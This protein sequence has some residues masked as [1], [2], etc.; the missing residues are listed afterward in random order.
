[1]NMG[2]ARPYRYVQGPTSFGNPLTLLSPDSSLLPIQS[3]KISTPSN[4]G[5]GGG[6]RDFTN[7]RNKYTPTK[8]AVI[9][10]VAVQFS[11]YPDVNSPQSE[12]GKYFQFVSDYMK[13]GS[14]VPITPVIKVPS[15][16]IQIGSPVSTYLLG[17][18]SDSGDMTKFMTDLNKAIGNQFDFS[19]VNQ[20]WIVG[21]PNVPAKLLS[22]QMNFGGD[23]QFG[24]FNKPG[25]SIYLEGSQ[26]F[27]S[28]RQPSNWTVDPWIT[29]HEIIGHQMGLDDHLGD[30]NPSAATT[31]AQLGTGAWG[32]MSGAEGE[33][34]LWDKWLAGWEDDSQIKCV[35]P[36]L[37]S[38][39]WLTPSSTK[40]N[41]VKGLVI[42]TSATTA[43]M[44]ESERSTGY[45]WKLPTNTNGALVY[46]IN[47]ADLRFSHGIEVQRPTNRSSSLF[48]NGMPLGDATLKIGESVTVGKVKIS[49]VEAG[50]FGDVIK[51]EPI[52]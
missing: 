24:N 2:C 44:V 36:S 46:T 21:P 31:P 17:S 4:P 49:V 33:F 15:S 19:G 9:Q 25:R 5:P 14:D 22:N 26:D 43:I 29:A 41:L 28:P 34:L 30:E 16:Y 47:S 50:D 18:D 32:M 3:C 8:S 27:T 1:M 11:D 37:T 42:P 7:E 38:T 20:V 51:V 23:F 39:I 10:V 13:N 48:F 6:Q 40:S 35:S 45:N 12:Y 52:A